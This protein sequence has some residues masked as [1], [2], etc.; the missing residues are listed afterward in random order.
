MDSLCS[1]NISAEKD[2]EAVRDVLS[3]PD[4]RYELLNSQLK[5]QEEEIRLLK[6]QLHALRLKHGHDHG[7]VATGLVDGHMNHDGAT[8]STRHTD[9]SDWLYRSER[10]AMHF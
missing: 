9:A 1:I 4:D 5:H 3:P 2:D 10:L 7:D 6:L 8:I